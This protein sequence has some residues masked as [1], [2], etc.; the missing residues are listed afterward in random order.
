MGRTKGIPN[1]GKRFWN[2]ALEKGITISDLMVN[3]GL[4]KNCISM[5]IYADSN[6]SSSSLAKLCKY[7]GISTDYVLGLKENE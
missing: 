7:V 5:F 3:S 4:S 1:A 6:I 2:K